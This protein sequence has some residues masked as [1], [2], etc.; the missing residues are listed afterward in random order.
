MVSASPEIDVTTAE[1][2]PMALLEADRHR[3]ATVVVDM[4][5]TRYCDVA[6]LNVLAEARRRALAEGGGLRLVIPEPHLR[7]AAE[8]ADRRA[9]VRGSTAPDD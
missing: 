9:T 4:T 2:L 8:R 1:Q 6:G 7:G 3:H 5:R